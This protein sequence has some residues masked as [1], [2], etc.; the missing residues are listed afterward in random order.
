MRIGKAQTG[1]TYLLLLF[2]MAIGGI[3]LAALGEQA[4]QR[5]LREQEAELAFRGAEIARAIAS[6]VD[7]D[8]AGNRALP[9]SVDALLEDRRSGRVVRHL[10]QLRSDPL[11]GDW[12]WL[13]PGEGGCSAVAPRGSSALG[14]SGVRS[15][16]SR[17]LLK[18][19][20]QQAK[21]ACELVFRHEA[22]RPAAPI[23]AS[24]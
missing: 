23:L 16:S 1:F 8:P 10:R 19:E 12:V 7:A 2:A 20:S 9:P 21:P 24:P 4:R 3:G 11:G 18:R 15:A 6:Y 17:L 13:A 14:W 5:A 22:Y